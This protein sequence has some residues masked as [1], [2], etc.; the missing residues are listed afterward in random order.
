MDE[1]TTALA[2]DNL[3]PEA[4]RPAFAAELRADLLEQYTPRPA[5][6]ATDRLTPR[7]VDV[8]LVM[9]D[10]RTYAQAA[11]ALGIATQT[12]RNEAF[13]AF[14]R[15]EVSGLIAAYRALGWLRP[16]R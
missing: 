2:T 3:P 13:E 7:Q 5:R 11:H 4:P 16:E 12:A 1:W 9:S 6:P 8:L 14:Q 15:L 10:G